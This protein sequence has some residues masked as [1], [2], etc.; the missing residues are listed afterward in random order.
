ME[1]KRDPFEKNNR[2]WKGGREDRP[3]LPPIFPPLFAVF[4]KGWRE[5]HR[6][7]RIDLT[8]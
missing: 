8:K 2:E 1:S 7:E 6:L 3:S 4:R 5:K